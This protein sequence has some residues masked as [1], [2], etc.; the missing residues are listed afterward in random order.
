[1]LAALVLLAQEHTT[2]T[3]AEEDST[4]FILPHADELIW[5]SIAFVILFVA[6]WKLAFPKINQMLA[7][8][9]AKI[10]SG[11]ESA[12]EAKVEADKL[13]G[14]YRK[15]LDESRGEAAKIIEEAKRT[16]ESL[17]R[18][19]VAKA[20]QEAQEIVQRARLD[21]AGEADRARQALQAEL[22]TLSL[23]LA[24]R[25]I[26]RELAQP[27]VAKQ[28]VERTIAELA[29]TGNGNGNGSNR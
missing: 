16:A 20:E 13:V 5:G 28:F 26:E 7:E 21:V 2:G 27:D 4:R 12:E 9:Q 3:G 14:Q 24:S 29:A 23:T 25:V 11:L 19:L 6:L 1:M 17:R 10:R 15:Q 8:R 18:D 22:V